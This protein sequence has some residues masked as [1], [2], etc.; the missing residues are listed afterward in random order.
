MTKFKA[1]DIIEVTTNS[2]TRKPQFLICKVINQ[3]T[4]K[5]AQYEIYSF[6][7][8]KKGIVSCDSINSKGKLI[9]KASK[10]DLLLYN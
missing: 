1:G 10:M 7:T 2:S 4:V 3:L 6:D 9:K 8:K 5:Y